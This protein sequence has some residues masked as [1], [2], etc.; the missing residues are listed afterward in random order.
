LW[1]RRREREICSFSW[2]FHRDRREE[3]KGRRER[4]GE[5]PWAVGFAYF[6][7]FDVVIWF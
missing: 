3:R 6:S 5:K 4:G 2:V 1:K 7:S